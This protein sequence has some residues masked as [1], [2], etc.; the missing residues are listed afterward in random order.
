M[1]PSLRVRAS[2]HLP[3]DAA[4]RRGSNGGMA[5]S[6]PA[7]AAASGRCAARWRRLAANASTS[8]AHHR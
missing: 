1:A 5:V 6:L 7:G 2:A 4:W 8:L 3:G